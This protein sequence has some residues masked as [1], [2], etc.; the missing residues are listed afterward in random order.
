MGGG[1]G[2]GGSDKTWCILE[3]KYSDFSQDLHSLHYIHRNETQIEK[4]MHT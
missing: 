2:L 1:A 4:K 3:K